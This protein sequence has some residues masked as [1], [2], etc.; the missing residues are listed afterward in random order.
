MNPLF[1]KYLM[2]YPIVSLKKENVSYFVRLYN[3]SQWMSGNTLKALQLKKFNRLLLY[4]MENVPYYKKSLSKSVV[5]T[6]SILIEDV[7]ILTKE[8]LKD[9]KNNLISREKFFFKTIKSTGGST[10][11]PVTVY[12][13]ASSMA[14]ERAALWRGYSWA[15]IHIGDRQARFWGIPFRK[16]ERLTAKAIDFI[17]NRYRLSAFDFDEDMLFLYYK[18]LCRYK[19]KYFYGYVSLIKIFGEFLSRNKLKLKFKLECI[20]TTAE[21]LTEEERSKIQEDFDCK[22][23]NEYGSGEIGTIAHE[24]EK[25]KLHINSENVY[26]EIID[27][28][29]K[30]CQDGTV[31]EII[32]TELN[33]RMMPI[34]RYKMGDFGSIE[35]KKCICGRELPILKGVYGRIYDV[36]NTPDGKK[37]HPAFFNYILKELKSK[38]MGVKQIQ[39][40]QSN[41]NEL[42]F[43]IVPERNYDNRTTETISS[44]IAQKMSNKITLNY[45]LV[46]KIEREKSGKFR[47]VKSFCNVS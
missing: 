34:I 41:I 36:I 6:K 42:I 30:H 22:V 16:K 12:K 1:A 24:C 26:I 7:P 20:I 17:N 40:L 10:G 2:F 32:V 28:D 25:G 19:P 11:E 39:V 45:K 9:N 21:E 29:G 35:N 18:N 4:S 33:N 27:K 23:Y 3:N 5:K 43:Y 46:D 37:Y 15:N 8:I 13:D 44:I 31:G 14:K 38:K 47:L